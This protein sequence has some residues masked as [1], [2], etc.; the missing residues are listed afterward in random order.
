MTTFCA[1]NHFRRQD[2]SYIC[3]PKSSLSRQKASVHFG[4]NDSI[5]WF[6]VCLGTMTLLP[7]ADGLKMFIQLLINSFA[8]WLLAGT[9]FFRGINIAQKFISVTKL[10]KLD[11][12][13][14]HWFG[15]PD[16][17]SGVQKGPLI[18]P[19]CIEIV[20]NQCTRSGWHALLFLDGK[21]TSYNSHPFDALLGDQVLY[22]I[23]F[24]QQNNSIPW[25]SCAYL[26]WFI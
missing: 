4:G 15:E 3:A 17:L 19:F 8:R 12:W 9:F 18:A 14:R 22:Q 24:L 6:F 16:I 23:H 20:C 26:Q 1:K 13:D 7:L 11:V 5:K 10:Q 2:P 25:K 21:F